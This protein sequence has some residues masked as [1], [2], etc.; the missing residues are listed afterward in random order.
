M[1]FFDSDYSILANRVLSL[2]YQN[3]HKILMTKA[4]TSEFLRMFEW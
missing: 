1:D 4:T 3:C 2:R